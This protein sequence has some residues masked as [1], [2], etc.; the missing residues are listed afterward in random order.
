M[1]SFV[2]TTYFF[3]VSYERI[4]GPRKKFATCENCHTHAKNMLLIFLFTHYKL[5]KIYL[6]SI[7]YSLAV[8]AYKFG[9]DAMMSPL[10]A[11]HESDQWETEFLV[12]LARSHWSE[13]CILGRTGN[14]SCLFSY[15]P[16][17]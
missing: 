4:L 10:C 1:H 13:I 5:S 7:F 15:F 14:S 16:N 2:G 3:H 8:A 6:Y 17:W 12:L 9:H 11:M